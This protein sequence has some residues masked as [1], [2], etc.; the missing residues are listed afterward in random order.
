MTDIKRIRQ[1]I[2]KLPTGEPFTSKAFRHT[3]APDNVKQI[4][5][6]LV[7]AGVIERAA[8]GVYIKPKVLPTIGSVPPSA[9]E[10]AKVLAEA[11]GETIVVHGAEAARQLQLTT[12]VP[13]QLIFYTNGN[14]RTLKFDNVDVQLKH[15]NPSRL[16]AAGSIVGTAISA[17]LYF[18]KDSV[19]NELIHRLKSKLSPKDFNKL[20][21]EVENM[22]AWLATAFHRFQKRT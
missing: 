5:S 12:Q 7:K 20:L 11:T 17:L 21:N 19:D 14:T 3:A 4:L 6:R 16:I 22:P 13:M 15:V 8:R 2:D 18:G 1:A 9:R 10:M